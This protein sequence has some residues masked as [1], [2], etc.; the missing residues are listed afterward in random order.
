MVI[1]IKANE[2]QKN[3]ILQKNIQQ[4]IN[5]IWVNESNEA[6][7]AADAYFD[8]TENE[9]NLFFK[10]VSAPVFKNAVTLT[11]KDFPGNYVRINAWPTFLERATWEASC[12]EELK[13]GAIHILQQLNI[14][15]Q[16]VADEP[17]FITARVLAMI[18]NE[19]FYALGEDVSTKQEIDIAMKLGTNYPYGPFEWADKIGINNIINLLNVLGLYNKTRYIAAPL[20]LKATG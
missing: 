16:F 5:I 6:T 11:G 1:V 3:I 7:N 8:L 15:V 20:L 13:E 4:G 2:Q 14:Q 17:G 19:A 12:T 18:I 10:D 9:S